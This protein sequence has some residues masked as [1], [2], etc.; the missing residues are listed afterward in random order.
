MVGG[1]VQQ[2]VFYMS[3]SNSYFQT[4]LLNGLNVS[5]FASGRAHPMGG[6]EQGEGGASGAAQRSKT[7]VLDESVN[8]VFLNEY[9][10][11]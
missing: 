6:G 4:S 10:M 8:C 2:P 1:N 7:G 3:L 11:S 9:K 5:V